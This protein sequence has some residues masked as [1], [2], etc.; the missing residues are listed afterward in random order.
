MPVPADVCD[1]IIGIATPIPLPYSPPPP[2]PTPEGII[3]TPPRAVPV[4]DE[5][6]PLQLQLLGS[7][8]V[9]MGLGARDRGCADVTMRAEDVAPQVH[10]GVDAADGDRGMGPDAGSGGGGHGLALATA[11][12]DPAEMRAEAVNG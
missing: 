2:A 1:I 8:V 6:L 9:A 4:V 5:P 12:T 3:P 11:A 10:V 7:V